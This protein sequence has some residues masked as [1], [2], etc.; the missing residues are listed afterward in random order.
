MGP[1]PGLFPKLPTPPQLDLTDGVISLIG[2]QDLQTVLIEFKDHHVI[3]LF[4]IWTTDTS[5]LTSVCQRLWS[6]G[7]FLTPWAAVVQQFQNHPSMMI[8]RSIPLLQ[9][10]SVSP[11]AGAEVLEFLQNEVNLQPGAIIPMQEFAETP[12]APKA[13]VTKEFPNLGVVATKAF[14][15]PEIAGAPN[16]P[17]FPGINLPGTKLPPEKLFDLHGLHGLYGLHGLQSSE[18]KN[19]PLEQGPYPAEQTIGDVR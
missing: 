18:L 6:Q 14:P 10:A 17:E 11:E 13:P 1:I 3:S 12:K 5:T 4:Q 2:D 19:R 16:E 9:R 8:P 15:N 7:W